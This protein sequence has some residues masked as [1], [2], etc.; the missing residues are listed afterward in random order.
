MEPIA[1]RHTAPVETATT[2]TSSKARKQS[3]YYVAVVMLSVG[4]PPAKPLI[5]RS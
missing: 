2:E 5:D 4:N 3:D 1:L